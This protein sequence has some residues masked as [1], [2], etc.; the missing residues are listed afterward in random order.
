MIGRKYVNKRTQHV[1]TVKDVIVKD[2]NDVVI[3]IN[4]MEFDTI[5]FFAW[6]YRD[7]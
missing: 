6:F 5:D 7:G 1:V 4:G 3:C 2:G